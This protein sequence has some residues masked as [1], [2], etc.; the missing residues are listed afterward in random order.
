L[1]SCTVAAAAG[2]A[3]GMARAPLSG[4]TPVSVVIAAAAKILRKEFIGIFVSVIIS[5]RLFDSPKSND[6]MPKLNGS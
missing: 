6:S 5:A 2:H 3:I 1:E 4:A